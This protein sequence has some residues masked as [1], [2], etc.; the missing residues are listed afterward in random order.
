MYSVS[1]I[2]KYMKKPIEIHLLVAK[3][4]LRYLQGTRDF[5]LIYKKGEK[6]ELFGFTDS[7]YARDHD[8]RRSTSS[9]VFMLGIGAVSWSSKKQQIVS[10]STTEVEFIGTTACACQAVWLGRILEEL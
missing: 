4:I 2:S 3:R 8:D 7:D 5:G 1:L 6:L 10:L 9:Y